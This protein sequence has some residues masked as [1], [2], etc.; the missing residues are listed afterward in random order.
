LSQL[1]LTFTGFDE[2]IDGDH[3]LAS[4]LVKGAYTLT[5]HSILDLTTHVELGCIVVCV[6]HFSAIEHGIKPILTDSHSA[7]E[8]V[9]D[10]CTRTWKMP[11]DTALSDLSTA[12]TLQEEEDSGKAQP[13]P[14]IIQQTI[15]TH[16]R[17]YIQETA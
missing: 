7:L 14:Q 3:N 5:V 10:Y 4:Y 13:A 8:I 2:I 15:P 6:D 17:L 1:S 12:T 9:R 16:P 11:W